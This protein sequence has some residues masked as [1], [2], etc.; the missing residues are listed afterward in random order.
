L[1]SSVILALLRGEV[2]KSSHGVFVRDYMH[3]QDVADA[4][5]ALFASTAQGAYNI[6]SGA[7]VTIRD[8][9][10][11]LG[12]ITGRSDLLQIGAL[13]ARANDVPL[14]LGDGRRM[15][16]DVGWK[17]KMDLETGLTATVAWWREQLSKPSEPST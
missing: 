13:P 2:A 17:P 5:V 16:A 9:V 15:L 10:L 8:I 6:A 11:Q 12:K 3:V 7:A 1:V 4:V 14:L